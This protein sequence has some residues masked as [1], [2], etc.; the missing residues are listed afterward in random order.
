MRKR[1]FER[2]DWK[3][4][5]QVLQEPSRIH[6][7]LHA[8]A[9]KES[10]SWQTCA[11]GRCVLDIAEKPVNMNDHV[12]CIS[13]AILEEMRHDT[14][15]NVYGLGMQF[16][17]DMDARDYKAADITRAEIECILRDHK[18]EIMECI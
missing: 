11:V 14:M 13:D 2:A 15:S 18:E 7:E 17:S 10:G 1:D 9:R 3:T 5:L 8:I 12:N 6:N 4:R 16:L